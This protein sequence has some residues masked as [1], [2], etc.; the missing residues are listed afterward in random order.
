MKNPADLNTTDLD[1]NK[2]LVNLP[3]CGR[4]ELSAKVFALI[5]VSAGETA[6]IYNTQRVVLDLLPPAL[7]QMPPWLL[8]TRL[9]REDWFCHW[10]RIRMA[11]EVPIAPGLLTA[12]S[13]PLAERRH[14]EPSTK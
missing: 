9:L 3:T 2:G 4:R 10:T 8:A 13:I 14:L 5:G 11:Q 7:P 12:M 1:T 6:A